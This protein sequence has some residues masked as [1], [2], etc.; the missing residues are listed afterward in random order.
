MKE[1]SMIFFLILSLF[2]SAYETVEDGQF[3]YGHSR[4]P[5]AYFPISYTWDGNAEHMDIYIPEEYNGKR[6]ASVGGVYGRGVP[7]PFSIV[8]P[9]EYDIPNDDDCAFVTY[10][11][12]L[13][14]D[15]EYAAYT[16]TIHIGPH[17]KEYEDETS[18]SDGSATFF[19]REDETGQQDVYYK[20]EY[21]Y[22][23]SESNPYLTV[24]D[25]KVCEIK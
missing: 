2:T 16:F 13:V 8:L 22:D 23:I 11:E 14:T 6:I 20:V 21:I 19:G 12:N 10:D 15:T 5:N 4:I 25:G 17:V 24:V 3:L 7:A 9:E 18:F 1:I